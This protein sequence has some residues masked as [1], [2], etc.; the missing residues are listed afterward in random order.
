MTAVLVDTSVWVAHFRQRNATLGTLLALDR[1]KSHPLV[2][3][4]IACGTPPSRAQV[5]TDL[6]NLQGIEQATFDEVLA[7]I[8]REHLQGLGCGWIDLCLLASTL[9]SAGAT[10]WTLDRRLGSLAK[11]FSAE[12]EPTQFH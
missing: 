5:L 10:L 9:L 8:D 3:G 1:V 7:F 6:Q 12:F 4:E 2:I 11:R